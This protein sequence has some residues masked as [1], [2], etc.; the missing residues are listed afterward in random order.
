MKCTS[1]SRISAH[2][3]VVTWMLLTSPL[4]KRKM[5]MVESS[6]PGVK[7]LL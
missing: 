2:L 5:M 1:I 7:K 4:S 6:K 3:M